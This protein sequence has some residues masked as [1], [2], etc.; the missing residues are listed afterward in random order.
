MGCVC[1]KDKNS[2][3]EFAREFDPNLIF[4]SDKKASGISAINA[5]LISK[6]VIATKIRHLKSLSI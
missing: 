6:D 1:T 5:D 2:K 3:N 4:M